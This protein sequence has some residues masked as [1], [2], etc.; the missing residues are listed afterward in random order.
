MLPYVTISIFIQIRK[1]NL[2]NIS[3]RSLFVFAISLITIQQ[4]FIVQQGMAQD[5][6]GKG[7]QEIKAD[8]LED[9]SDPGKWWKVENGA[10]VAESKGGRQLPKIHYLFWNGSIKG[11]FELSLEYRILANQPRDAGV[12]FR[13]EHRHKMNNNNLIGYQAELDTAI[14]YG[15]KPFLKKGKLFGNIHDGKRGRMFRRGVSVTIEPD[16]EE[17]SKPLTKKFIPKR[18][19]RKPPEWNVC[20]IRVVG[21][22][23]KLYLNG[24]L[25]NEIIDGD[26]KMKS[27]GDAIALQ[28]R[29]NNHYR[30]EVK[31]LKY[32]LLK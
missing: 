6:S 20:T 7:W 29:P 21:H 18:V 3:T 30:F 4:I 27:T 16:G 11:D 2:M 13:I 9:W 12:N 23:I 5:Q 10:F 24:K 25:A 32:K 31:N 17:T 15:K 28:F 22:H 26:T 8:S 14:L 19:F 1:N